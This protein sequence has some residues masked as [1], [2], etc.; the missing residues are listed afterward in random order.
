VEV[1]PAAGF[2]RWARLRRHRLG[3]SLRLRFG[4]RAALSHNGAAHGGKNLKFEVRR[5]LH[6]RCGKRE[7]AGYWSELG[8]LVLALLTRPKMFFE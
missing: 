7:A 6:C 1:P 4:L 3:P 8:R 5:W 2:A